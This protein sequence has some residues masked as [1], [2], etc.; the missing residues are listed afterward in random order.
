MRCSILLLAAQLFVKTAVSAEVSLSTNIQSVSLFRDGALV[1]RVGSASVPAGSTTLL[2]ADI[3]TGADQ[4]ALQASLV[5]SGTALIR[6]AKVHV[7]SDEEKSEA[8]INAEQRLEAKQREIRRAEQKIQNAQAQSEY[9]AQIGRSFAQRY[10]QIEESGQLTLG[11]AKETWAYID[12]IKTATQSEILQLETELESL[13]EEATE[14]QQ[15]LS[16]AIE[17][18]AKLRAT[19]AVEI[20]TDSEQS[21]ELHVSYF[22]RQ[23]NWQPRYELRAQPDEGVVKF[24]YFAE[25]RQS[26]GEDW[27]GATLS[28]HSNHAGRSGNAPELQPLR[29]ERSNDYARKSFSISSEAAYD[30]AG[31]MTKKSEPFPYADVT[32]STVSFQATL[33]TTVAVP[34]SDDATTLPVLSETLTATF[35]SE[36]V[37]RAQL[38][39][40]LIGETTNTL[41]LPILP[42]QALAFV[43]GRLSSKVVLAKTLPGEDLE[44]SF[45]VDAMIVVKRIEGAHEDAES[46]FIDKTT[47]L[48]R[49]YTTQV[50]S[51]HA[52]DHKVVVVDQFP[53]SQN[54]KIEILRL[55]PS[56]AEVVITEE[57]KD[58]GIFQWEA[59]LKPQQTRSFKTVYEAIY[60]RDWSLQ[61]EL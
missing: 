11:Q 14:L 51:Y 60:P 56:D 52:V 23:A 2:L 26:T 35:W 59:V 8:V 22:V 37:P 15:E 44:L 13:R 58:A 1:T 21:I 45:G 54:A 6:N 25:V 39:A 17:Q 12:Q 10:G 30:D 31:G 49:E 38:E 46:G 41:A 20:D 50:T 33:P 19:T 16:E 29:V 4:N 55:S 42:G 32:T 48:H 28:L 57:N 61:P 5:D 43:D 34:S 53:V 24:G 27:S 40:Y 36:T 7:P 18:D 47:T 3:P 9:A